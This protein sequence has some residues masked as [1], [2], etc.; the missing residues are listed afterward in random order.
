[1]QFNTHATE[2]DL[3]S[4]TRRLC[5][6]DSTSYHINDVTRRIN[7]ALE[8]LIAD[9]ITADGTWQYDDTNH[10]TLPRGKGTLVEGQEAYSFASEYLTGCCDLL[11]GI[12]WDR[13]PAVSK[14]DKPPRWHYCLSLVIDLVRRN[15]RFEVPL[16]DIPELLAIVAPR[17]QL[18]RVP[19]LRE[20]LSQSAGKG[21]ADLFHSASSRAKRPHRPPRIPPLLGSLRGA[22]P[23]S[24][25]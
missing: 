14:V 7:A 22:L 1:M 5:D 3:V 6:A 21:D 11:R 23:Y 17:Y 12:D 13:P 15:V 19:C 24:A 20:H 8:E 10:T 25:G 9:I 4:E 16:V 2:Q 18:G